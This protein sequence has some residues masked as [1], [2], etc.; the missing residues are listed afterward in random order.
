MSVRLR[1]S[2]KPVSGGAETTII[3]KPNPSFGYPA[4]KLPAQ[5]APHERTTETNRIRYVGDGG[6]VQQFR[7]ATTRTGTL[8][9]FVGDDLRSFFKRNDDEQ[10][11]N[12]RDIQHSITY[13]T[14]DPSNSHVI[15][16]EVYTLLGVVFRSYSA[17]VDASNEFR[18]ATVE[19][20][21][22]D[23]VVDEYFNNE[24]VQTV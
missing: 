10:V 5:T 13:I 1:N 4:F 2:Y 24:E 9:F 17:P 6:N 19:F 14:E 21:Y 18:I 12:G 15:G 7:G 22:E 11:K 20:T 8:T 16:R 3:I 23:E